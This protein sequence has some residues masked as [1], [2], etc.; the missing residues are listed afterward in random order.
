M[1]DIKIV[2]GLNRELVKFIAMSREAKVFLV[3]HFEIVDL[4]VSVNKEHVEELKI[5]LKEAGLSIEGE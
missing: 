2:P 5:V 3:T 1:S 4:S